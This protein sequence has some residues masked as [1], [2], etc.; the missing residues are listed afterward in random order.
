MHA[1]HPGY[2]VVSQDGRRVRASRKSRVTRLSRTTNERADQPR[3]ERCL[4]P[5]EQWS[6]DSGPAQLG[7][8]QSGR[9]GSGRAT[10]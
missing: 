8:A 9:A 2:D 3:P 10:P 4:A 1:M 7:L 6:E 5:T